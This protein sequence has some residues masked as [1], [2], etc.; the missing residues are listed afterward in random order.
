MK[1]ISI[2]F[3]FLASFSLYTQTPDTP[4]EMRRERSV[5]QAGDII[6]K[7][8]PAVA[9][10][11]TL[12]AGD[13]EGSWQFVKSFS[14]NLAATYVLKYALNKPR[15]EGA[16]DGLAFPSGHTSVAFQSAAFIQRRYGWKYG[17]PAFLLA[18]F[19]GYSR[20]EGI[21][22]R[23]DGWDVLGGI[24]VGVGSTYLFTTPYQRE[25]F[26][27][28]FSGGGGSYSIGIVYKF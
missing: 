5:E 18:G 25:H 14:A 24:A 8:L 13:T 17:I 26:E 22:D 1:A 21:N 20:I 3:L 11:S 16:S 7:A 28:S 27:L 4:S 12:L 9:G 15:P 10:L 6:Q 19:V 2:G 23:H